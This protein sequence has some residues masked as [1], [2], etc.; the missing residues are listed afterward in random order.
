MLRPFARTTRALGT[1][2][3]RS[4]RR[5][6]RRIRIHTM[7]RIC[8]TGSTA[9]S[10]VLKGCVNLDS[11][12]TA[13]VRVMPPQ[14]VGGITSGSGRLRRWRSVDPVR[15]IRGP[16]IV[17]PLHCC[18]CGSGPLSICRPSRA[19]VGAS[20]SQVPV[21]NSTL[22]TCGNACRVCGCGDGVGWRVGDQRDIAANV[23]GTAGK[24]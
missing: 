17:D 1:E 6:G 16:S 2:R 24:R 9:S 12:F 11:V 10:Q 18:A 13:F 23:A 8:V 7:T 5:I 20:G 14:L 15:S 21:G 19:M 3:P 22:A 4:P